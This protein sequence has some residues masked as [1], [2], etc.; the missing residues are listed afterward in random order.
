MLTDRLFIEDPHG[1]MLP[2]TP[3]TRLLVHAWAAMAE[4]LVLRWAEEPDGVS[5]DEVLTMLSESLPALLGL[6]R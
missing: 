5:R 2:D 3:Q 6:V 4:G 1:L